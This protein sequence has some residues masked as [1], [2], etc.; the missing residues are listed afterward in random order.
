M[1]L[2]RLSS[3]VLQVMQMSTKKGFVFYGGASNFPIQSF[4][5]SFNLAT[6]AF[7]LSLELFCYL[8]IYAFCYINQPVI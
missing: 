6:L 2:A 4:G 7:I 1:C 5:A 8:C 3:N